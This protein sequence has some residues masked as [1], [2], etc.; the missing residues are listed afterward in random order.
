MTQID[1]PEDLLKNSNLE[2]TQFLLEQPENI[3]S[4]DGEVLVF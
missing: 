4:A 3:Q 1:I 2:H